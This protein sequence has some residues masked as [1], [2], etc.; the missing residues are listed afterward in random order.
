[1]YRPYVTEIR[2]AHLKAQQAERSGMYHV[3]VQ[4]YLICLEK[5]ECRQD[6]Q[7][8]NYFAQQLSN[9]YRQMGLLDKANFYAGL[10]HLD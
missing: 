8:V 1:M 9:C 2:T 4:Q 3:A 5:S 6:C 10:A 7:C